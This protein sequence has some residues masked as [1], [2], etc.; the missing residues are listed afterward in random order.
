[1]RI[2]DAVHRGTRSGV[3]LHARALERH[4]TGV[5]DFARVGDLDAAIAQLPDIEALA[6]DLPTPAIRTPTDGC[7]RQELGRTR[8]H[9]QARLRLCA[10]SRPERGSLAEAALLVVLDV[11]L[12]DQSGPA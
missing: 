3:P 1:M 6:A 4:T 10:V 2:D 12:P 5:R 11:G 8:W 9:A 7:E